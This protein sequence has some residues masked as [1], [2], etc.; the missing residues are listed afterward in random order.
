MKSKYV[1]VESR[2]RFVNVNQFIETVYIS[3]NPRILVLEI[4]VVVS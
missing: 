4:V 2:E 1:L 3:T